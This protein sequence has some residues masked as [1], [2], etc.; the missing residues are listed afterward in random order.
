MYDEVIEGKER[1]IEALDRDIKS[2]QQ[3]SSELGIDVYTRSALGR[4][5]EANQQ[6]FA[7]RM[8]RFNEQQ[9]IKY[10]QKG[11]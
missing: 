4:Q 5:I 8:K 1:Q 2:K 9:S 3:R 7:E 10:I 6:A 11:R